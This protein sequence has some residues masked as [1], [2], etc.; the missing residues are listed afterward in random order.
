MARLKS[1]QEF[2][3]LGSGY[4]LAF[5][6]LQIRGAG[7]LLG[8]RQHGAMA[9]VGYELYSQLIGEEVKFLKAHADGLS[10]T[11]EVTYSDPLAGLQ[12]LPSL[13]L[14]VAAFIPDSYV[15]EEGQRLYCYKQLMAAREVKELDA[16]REEIRDRYGPMPD[17]VTNAFSVM[18]LRLQCRDLGIE[19]VDGNGGRLLV[20]FYAEAEV[21]SR[22]FSLMSK[23]NRECYVSRTGLVWPFVGNSLQSMQKMLKSLSHAISQ[24]ERDREAFANG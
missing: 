20:S 8:A 12:P 7:E 15:A 19:K 21:S 2:S 24:V 5:R 1:L 22:V 16:T 11:E 6:D 17:E 14:P 3:S 9:T 13:D 10:A 23:E 4:S 18:L